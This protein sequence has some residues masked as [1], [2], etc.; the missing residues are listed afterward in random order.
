MVISFRNEKPVRYNMYKK[1]VKTHNV[2][3]KITKN[4]K[5]GENHTNLEIKYK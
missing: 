3:T 4:K 2:E 1:Y 5:N